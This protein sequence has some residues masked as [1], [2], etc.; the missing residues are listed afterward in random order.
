MNKKFENALNPMK[1]K[2]STLY[3]DIKA[4]EEE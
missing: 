3:S 2:M 4:G 1:N